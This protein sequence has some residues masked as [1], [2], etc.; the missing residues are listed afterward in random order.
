M[1]WSLGLR[2]GLGLEE[3]RGADPWCVCLPQVSA[4]VSVMDLVKNYPE[5]QTNDLK[6]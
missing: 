6:S 5:P 3:C 2:A 1:V 4:E